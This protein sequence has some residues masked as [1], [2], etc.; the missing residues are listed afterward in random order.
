MRRYGRTRDLR[1]LV[2]ANR[3]ITDVTLDTAD[4]VA[5]AVS[6]M[7][8]VDAAVKDY[9]GEDDLAKW[10]RIFLDIA[11]VARDH[12]VDIDPKTLRKLKQAR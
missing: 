3:N 9:R 6:L 4:E 11:A 5:S 10:R 8:A 7:K 12:G 2:L 1:D